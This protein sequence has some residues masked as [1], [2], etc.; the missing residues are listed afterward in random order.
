MYNLIVLLTSNKI[1]VKT[2]KWRNSMNVKLCNS[3]FPWADV[4]QATE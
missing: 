3:T 1:V 4:S 2:V